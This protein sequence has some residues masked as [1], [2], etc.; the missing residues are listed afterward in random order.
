[1]NNEESNQFRSKITLLGFIKDKY[2]GVHYYYNY[3]LR[4]GLNI[5][6]MVDREAYYPNDEAI[7]VFSVTGDYWV[8][9]LKDTNKAL[10]KVLGLIYE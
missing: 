10:N 7:Y 2:E 8:Y 9:N 3:N 4:S 5:C 1:M 6:V